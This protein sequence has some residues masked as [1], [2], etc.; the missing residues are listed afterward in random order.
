MKMVQVLDKV[1]LADFVASAV[2][3]FET[4]QHAADALRIDRRHLYRL[5]RGETGNRI[6]RDLYAR[7]LMIIPR[8]Q[9][10]EFRRAILDPQTERYL[11]QYRSWLESH[12]KRF[13][14]EIVGTQYEEPIAQ[15]Q[16]DK[17]KGA[18]WEAVVRELAFQSLL[19]HMNG[20][21]PHK[22]ILTDFGKKA[23]G[24]GWVPRMARYQLAL[25]R[26]IE[27][28][29]CDAEAGYIER[30]PDEL[31]RATTKGRN[32]ELAQYL[33]VALKAEL[34]LLGRPLAIERAQTLAAN[35][36]E[37]ELGLPAKRGK[38]S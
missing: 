10:D 25:R 30:W 22:E 11:E 7:L 5:I 15:A 36:S 14:V 34:F 12:L 28:L 37:N 2:Q 1:L 26:A 32:D 27:P 19:R 17:G 16:L 21:S 6:N 35:F 24:L 29:I 38:K 33:S 13:N 8:D 3:L 18:T 4:Q 23:Q 31:E 9:H 20:R